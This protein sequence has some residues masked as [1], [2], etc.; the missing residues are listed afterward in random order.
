MRNEEKVPN[1][2]GTTIEKRKLR[3]LRSRSR[4]TEATVWI[5]KEGAS[6]A[7]VS[8]VKSQLK[9]R[10]LVKV[11]IH[12]PALQEAGASDFAEKIAASTGSTLV[13]V[14]GHTFTLYK[15]RENRVVERKKRI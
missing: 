13:E 3:G 10:E 14:L 1:S 9:T 8:Q 7:L 4:M 5:G 6:D 2:E 12:K 11:K 15:K